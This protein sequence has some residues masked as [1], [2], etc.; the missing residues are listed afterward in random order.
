MRGHLPMP[1]V[2]TGANAPVLATVNPGSV[3]IEISLYKR[4]KLCCSAAPD[5]V[6][7]P[8]NQPDRHVQ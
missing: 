1:P 2:T 4:D 6:A 7:V 3:V 8:G 5:A